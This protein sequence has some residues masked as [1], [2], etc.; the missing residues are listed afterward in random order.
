MSKTLQV[1]RTQLNKTKNKQKTTEAPTVSSGGQI[2]KYQLI[3]DN[4]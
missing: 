2:G 4:K 3:L 1:H